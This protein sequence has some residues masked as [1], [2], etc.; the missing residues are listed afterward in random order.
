[1]EGN[2]F[3]NVYYN[4]IIIIQYFFMILQVDDLRIKWKLIYSKNNNKKK[5]K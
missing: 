3:I 4:N 1:M 5:L 2:T